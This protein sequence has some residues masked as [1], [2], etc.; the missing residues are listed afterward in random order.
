MRW[1]ALPAV[2]PAFGASRASGMRSSPPAAEENVCL[3]ATHLLTGSCRTVPLAPRSSAPC[4]SLRCSSFAAVDSIQNVDLAGCC[5][6]CIENQA[7]M[8]YSLSTPHLGRRTCFLRSS[9]SAAHTAGECTS[10]SV[11]KFA[12]K[13]VLEASQ[14]GGGGVIRGVE[15]AYRTDE[16]SRKAANLPVAVRRQRRVTAPPPPTSSVFS[17]APAGRRN[18]G[19]REWFALTPPPL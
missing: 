14:H 3:A 10:G 15:P 12:H 17:A 1:G 16:F 9:D 8:A 18:S 13:E 4:P 11:R 6:A 7:C 19:G 5:A 2:L